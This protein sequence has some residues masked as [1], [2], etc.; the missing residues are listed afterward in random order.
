MRGRVQLTEGAT[1]QLTDLRNTHRR[2]PDTRTRIARVLRPLARFPEMGAALEPGAPT[3]GLRFVLGPWLW[4]LIV[5]TVLEDRVVVVA[6]ED[7]RTSNA[8]TT[9]RPRR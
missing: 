4:M 7:A 2:L 6:I 9:R 8:A 5:Y 3:R 1:T